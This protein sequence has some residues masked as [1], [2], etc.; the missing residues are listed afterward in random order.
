MTYLA[1]TRRHLRQLSLRNRQLEKHD[2]PLPLSPK[3]LSTSSPI[4]ISYP[5]NHQNTTT[6]AASSLGT[7]D[8]SLTGFLRR[9]IVTNTPSNC[10]RRYVATRPSDRRSEASHEG[11]RPIADGRDSHDQGRRD[12]QGNGD[13]KGSRRCRNEP[14][15]DDHDQATPGIGRTI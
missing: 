1:S 10:L 15:H 8:T 7:S 2:G 6:P 9:G 11:P 4:G 5:L 3:R 12:E 14:R 13:Q